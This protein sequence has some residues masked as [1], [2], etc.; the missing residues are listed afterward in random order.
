MKIVVTCLCVL[1]LASTAWAKDSDEDF[2]KAVRNFGYV[3]GLVHQCAQE[4]QKLAVEKDVL[5]VYTGLVSLFGSDE[6]FFYAAAF[7]AGSTSSYNKSK[8]KEYQDEF[9][10][11]MQ[12]G[13]VGKK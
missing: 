10:D 3:S 2:E 12:R 8:C 9:K 5:K 7:G 4:G 13:K 11:K 6:A 1:L